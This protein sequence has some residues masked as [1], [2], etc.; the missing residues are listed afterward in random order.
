MLSDSR[1]VAIAATALWQQLAG[2][3]LFD[4]FTDQQRQAFLEAYERES[5]MG[6][7]RFERGAVICRKG[8]Y[9]LDF[10]VILSGAV[11]LLDLDG[12][13]NRVRVAT[14]EAPNFYGELGAIGGLPRT[15]DV[16]GVA[17]DT[18][19][20]YIPRHALKYLEVN[21]HARAILEHRYRERAVRVV[22]AELE[23]FRGV[24]SSFIEELIPR[25]EILRY[26]LRGIP[27][28]NQGEAG[29][30][31]YIVR[32]GFVQVVHERADGSKRV[33]AYPR[34]G[35]YFGEM[36][37]L[38]PGLHAVGVRS[39]SVLTAGK[40]ELIKIRGEDFIELCRRYP[41]VEQDVRRVIHQRSE[42][43]VAGAPPAEMHDRVGAK[44]TSSTCHRT[45]CR[46]TRAPSPLRAESRTN[47]RSTSRKAAKSRRRARCP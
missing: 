11:D 25:C 35:E 9:E 43:P 37:L 27:L 18:R 32:D 45:R 41:R 13:G 2:L 14:F 26:E 22:A 7:R 33:L 1:S 30:A 40:C 42:R 34:S 16:V 20:F 38:E 15:T 24:P 5:G 17:D 21:P 23:L 29:D 28:V 46:R 39:A 8:E 47:S 31:L 3:D 12:H 44:Q 4:R 36:A 6:V 19:I 10:C